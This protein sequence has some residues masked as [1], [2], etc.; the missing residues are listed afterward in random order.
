MEIDVRTSW[1][2]YLIFVVV[3]VVNIIVAMSVLRLFEL[4]FILYGLV[5]I[6]FQGIQL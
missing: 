6:V 5:V 3:V 4:L 1:H 2:F